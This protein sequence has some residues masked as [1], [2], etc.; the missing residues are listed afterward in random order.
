MNLLIQHL[1]FVFLESILYRSI[2]KSLESPQS[3]S[4]YGSYGDVPSALASRP[5]P[6]KGNRSHPYFPSYF[7]V[8]KDETID[9][10]T[11]HSDND[12]GELEFTSLY[13]IHF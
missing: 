1:T 7:R 2:S 8:P 12:S 6:I 3:N 13:N 10:A 11:W 5:V 4:P 9:E